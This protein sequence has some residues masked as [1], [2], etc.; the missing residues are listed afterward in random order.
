MIPLLDN[1]AP[2]WDSAAGAARAAI[3]D[4]AC[5]ASAVPGTVLSLS[6]SIVAGVL[7]YGILGYATLFIAVFSTFH[8]LWLALRR[9]SERITFAGKHVL[10]T[11]GSQGLGR[12]LAVRAYAAGARVT[13]VARTASKLEKACEEISEGA[14]SGGG[15]IQYLTMDVKTATA[16]DVRRL[17]RA[18][19]R[20]READPATR[21][22]IYRLLIPCEAKRGDGF[23]RVDVFVANAGTGP[24]TLVLEADEEELDGMMEHVIETNLV[25]TLRCVNV[26]ANM[27]ASDGEGGRISIV[28]S[29]AGLISLPGY[30]VYSA[31]KVR[32]R[33][34]EARRGWGGGRRGWG[35]GMR[36]GRRATV[37]GGGSACWKDRMVCLDRMGWHVGASAGGRGGTMVVIGC[38]PSS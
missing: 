28:S 38:L 11:G 26:V 30:A 3:R 33:G 34:L 21:D 4:P 15:Q 22:N 7:G 8:L 23:G 14:T 25:G 37:L 1:I 18:A 32:A 24:A 16:S 10:I 36:R 6:R 27:M 13:I 9:R 31:T 29:A 5:A 19:A 35:G 20:G 12:A 17:M 2:L